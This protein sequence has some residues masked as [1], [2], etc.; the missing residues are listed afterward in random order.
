M[1]T[2]AISLLLT[3]GAAFAVLVIVGML[4]GNRRAIADALAGR[5]G[6]AARCADGTTPPMPTARVQVGVMRR[7]RRV[8]HARPA[9]LSSVRVA[10]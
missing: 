4:R 6:F 2:F 5:G 10:A 9:P 1:L 8:S 3:A 7:G